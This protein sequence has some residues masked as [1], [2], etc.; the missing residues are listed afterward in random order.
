MKTLKI[1]IYPSINQ[2]NI[3]NNFINTSRFVYN[4]TLE[5]IKKHGYDPN[6]QDLRNLLATENTRNS[7]LATKIYNNYINILK[8]S[9]KNEELIDYEI[10]EINEE[11]K[12]LPLLKNPLINDFE[13][14]TSNE[15]RSNAIK[16]V[17]DS[18]KSGFTNLKSGNIKYFNMNFKKSTSKR[19]TIELA[20]TDIKLLNNCV[21]ISPSKFPKDEIDIKIHKKMYK[22]IK[23]IK[24]LNNCDL[25]KEQN[26][27]FIHVLLPIK[28]KEKDLSNNRFCG[29]DPGIRTFVSIYGNKEITEIELKNNILEKY[30]KKLKFLK[31]LRT[32]PRLRK[33]RNKYRKRHLNKIEKKK[34]SITDLLHWN[35][36]NY[37]I[38]TQDVI[39]FGDI[40]SHNIVKINNIKVVNRQFNDLKFYIFKKRLLYKCIIN[41]KKVFFINES[42]TSQ[43]CSSCGV[44]WKGLGSSKIYKCQ[45]C[46]KVFDRDLNAA[47]NICMRGILL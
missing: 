40:K 26:K 43:T 16:S 35:V 33:K 10:K 39:F 17:C 38:K 13:L 2:K 19:Q 23:N 28:I 5:Y 31:N 45:N 37:L 32:M 36:I 24:I 6:F 34:N 41:K 25:V 20:K 7:Y 4:R 46:N 8:T 3:L 9:N 29:V 15:I 12:K 14:N 21:R 27:F 42:Y 22:K 44:L 1:Q 18:Y 30:N 11:L 47:K